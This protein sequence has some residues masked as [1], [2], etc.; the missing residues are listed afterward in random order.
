MVDGD[1]MLEREPCANFIEEEIRFSAKRSSAAVIS[2]P[3]IP[4]S[5]EDNF[6]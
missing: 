5:G 4:T 3:V 1:V 2:V 6:H